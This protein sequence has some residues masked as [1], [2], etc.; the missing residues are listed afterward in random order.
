MRKKTDLEKL[1]DHLNK[2]RKS[3]TV[4]F[5]T[6]IEAINAYIAKNG[7]ITDEYLMHGEIEKLVDDLILSGAWIHDRLR[8]YTGTPHHHTYKKTL[9]KKVRKAIGYTL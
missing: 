4:I 3:H 5:S 9:T 7:H 8:G 6:A 2:C 1:N